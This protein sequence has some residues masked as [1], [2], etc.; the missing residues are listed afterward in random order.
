MKSNNACGAAIENRCEAPQ[1]KKERKQRKK[2]NK[3]N[4]FLPVRSFFWSVV[5][6]I[7]VR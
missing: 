7:E 3:G 5:F 6:T 1:K 2:K 4:I